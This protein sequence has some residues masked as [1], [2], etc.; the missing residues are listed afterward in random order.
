MLFFYHYLFK[1]LIICL[2]LFFLDGN[3]FIRSSNVYNVYY[4]EGLHKIED[5]FVRPL[6]KEKDESI[7]N[8]LI[9][10]GRKF[11]KYAIGRHYL[12]DTGNKGRKSRVM[13]DHQTYSAGYYHPS[14]TRTGTRQA[15]ASYY[16]TFSGYS[17]P[18]VK[19]DK[20]KEEEL[21]M[22]APSL[23][24]FKFVS[25]DWEDINVEFLD[26]IILNILI[27]AL[28]FIYMFCILFNFT[29]NNI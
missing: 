11:E 13:I 25:K 2:L 12:Q 10:R 22:C 15:Y 24:G 27:L 9:T 26:G 20:V 4:W 18:G 8:K 6:V 7:Y 21:F 17:T 29:R 5:L 23:N 16:P 1:I 28:L 3:S 14:G 19:E